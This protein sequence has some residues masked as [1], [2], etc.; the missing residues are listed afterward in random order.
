[1]NGLLTKTTLKKLLNGSEN[2]FWRSILRDFKKRLFVL[3]MENMIYWNISHIWPK[4][5]ELIYLE[6]TQPMHENKNHQDKDEKTSFIFLDLN[7]IHTFIS[8][9]NGHLRFRVLMVEI[10]SALLNKISFHLQDLQYI[11]KK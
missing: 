6:I 2:Q 11:S 9:S 3:R 4:F 7:F 5:L 1:M 8:I 10:V